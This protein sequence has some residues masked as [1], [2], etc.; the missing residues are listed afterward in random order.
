MATYKFEYTD[1][2]GGEPNYAW[3]KRGRV[4]VPE[5][6]HYGYDGSNGY[7]KADKAQMREAVRMAK[8]HVGLTNVK[9]RRD[10]YGDTIQL[11]PY[12]HNTALFIDW[13]DNT[14]EHDQ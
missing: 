9:C 2:F 3:V 5:L 10:E 13:C 4:D 8:A 11:I 14:Q 1:L 7:A 12:G 6:T